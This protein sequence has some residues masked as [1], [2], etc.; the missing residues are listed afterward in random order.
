M[1]RRNDDN[2]IDSSDYNEINDDEDL[3]IIIV[4]FLYVLTSRIPFVVFI[5]NYS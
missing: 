3:I 5:D 2:D 1:L 4:S